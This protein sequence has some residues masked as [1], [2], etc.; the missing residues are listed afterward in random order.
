M[1]ERAGGFLVKWRASPFNYNRPQLSSRPSSTSLIY[2]YTAYPIH[3]NV[4]CHTSWEESPRNEQL[5]K[6]QTINGK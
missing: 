1:H 3:C 4:L 2:N 6:P 5:I